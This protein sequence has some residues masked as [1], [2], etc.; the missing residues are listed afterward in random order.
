M[1]KITVRL[2]RGEWVYDD[3]KPLGKPGGFG[4]VF[5]GQG[6]DGDIAVKRL[7][8]NAAEA[9]HR[10]LNISD[11]L[12]GRDLVHVVPVLDAGQDADSDRYFIIMPVCE[13]SLQ[14]LMDKNANGVDA[15]I[16]SSAV[17]AIIKG[18]KEVG[19]LTHRDLKPGNVLFH[20]GL[21][22]IADFGIAKFVEDSTSIDTLRDSL[23]PPYAA[24]EQ[25]L[26]ERP[27]SATDVYAL[28]CIIHTL[29]T[30]RPP[31]AGSVD[32]IRD[33]HLH[34]APN[35]TGMLSQRLEVFVSH[36]LRKPPQARPTLDRCETVLADIAAARAPATEA[37]SVFAQAAQEIAQQEATE[38]AERI[39]RETKRR[40]R[41]ALYN[42]AAQELSNI[43][44]RLFAH[45]KE[46]SESVKVSHR[47]VLQFGYA[48]LDISDATH[49][50]A[51]HISVANDRRG[52]YE[53]A[54][55]DVLGWSEIAVVCEHEAP[56]ET[57]RWSASL[58]YVDRNDGNG[59]RWYEVAFWRMMQ[60]RRGETQPFSLK[61]YEADIYLALSNVMHA[62]NVAYGPCPIDGEDEDAFIDRWMGLVAKAATRQLRPP[63]GM[64][65]N[66]FC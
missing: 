19:D 40:Q 50:D 1:T 22:K 39:A 46:Q 26:G 34:T 65:I 21:W 62:V 11:R 6:A 30:G 41:E 52:A 64:P 51:T 36:M 13:Y 38:E 42:D 24:P 2:P 55:L 45:I 63:S 10:E 37:Q 57:Y 32:D 23:S 7:K 31:F 28:G 15:S 56:R 25:W 27:S 12:I 48:G 5:L 9:A 59:F 43:K 44:A 29:M 20:N 33:H 49:L 14:D 18:L 53:S 61:G 58:L 4:E 16:A 3:D 8:L 66:N 35:Q 17:A 47:G 60:S 54:G